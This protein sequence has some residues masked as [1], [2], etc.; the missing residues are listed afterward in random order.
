MLF[1]HKIYSAKS[2]FSYTIGLHFLFNCFVLNPYMIS[3][4]DTWMNRGHVYTIV[5][6]QELF[7]SEGDYCWTVKQDYDTVHVN[8]VFKNLYYV[9]KHFQITM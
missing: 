2:T 7:L 8:I 6:T 5:L 1:I 4:L 3:F 9:V